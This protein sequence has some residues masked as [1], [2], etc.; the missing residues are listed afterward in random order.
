MSNSQPVIAAIS[1]P[2]A[3]A[4][5]GVIRLS[6]EGAVEL[7]E[8]VFRPASK[9]RRL[10]GLPGYTALYGTVH[11]RE[12]DIDECVALVFR[13]P[14][15]YTGE[16]VVELSCHGGLYLLQRTLRAVLDAGARPAGAGEF[17]RRAFLNGKLD[18]TRAEAV[19]DLIAANGK[20]AAKAALAAREGAVYRRLEEVKGILLG[21]AANLSAYVDYPDDDI[22]ELSPEALGAQLSQA[23]DRIRGLLDT[24]DAG[25]ILREGVDTVIV[26]SPNVGKSTLMNRLAGCERSIVTPV[27]GTT[28]D[29]VEETVRLGDVLLRLAD[30]AGLRATEDEVES[31]GVRRA[32]SR[33]ETA[34]LLLVVFDGSRPLTE[35]DR[36]MAESASRQ[37]AVAVINKVDLGLDVNEEYIRSIFQRAVVV[38]AR[39]GEGLPALEQAVREAVGLAGID[40][41]QPLL[42]N[43]R[44]RR[45]AAA[46]LDCLEEAL[47]ALAAGMTLDAVG[48]DIDGAVSALLELTGERAT[49]AVVD[50]VF[51]RFC[52]GK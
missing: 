3:P 18:F 16:E 23:R 11:D 20:L 43:E 44:Q 38:S 17:T 26:G 22:P 30:T 50:E 33:M 10:S 13:A 5:L 8:R 4:G 24:Y 12:G 35:D 14:H 2:L 29:V 36:R 27:A 25:R 28:R 19:M 31:I 52:V 51:A 47:A 41:T 45:C 34:A 42:A 32:Q 7:A 37:N 15:S 49:E 21:A 39:D 40:G 1:T 6:G 46:C 48:V 9:T